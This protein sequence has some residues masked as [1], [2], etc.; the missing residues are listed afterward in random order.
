MV[1]V[2]VNLLALGWEQILTLVTCSEPLWNCLWFYFLESELGFSF[3]LSHMLTQASL[4]YRLVENRDRNKQYKYKRISDYHIFTCV[5]V[6]ARNPFIIWIV[7]MSD[8]Y[9]THLMALCN[10][11]SV[12]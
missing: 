10:H 12:C 11:C 7:E 9:L 1:S 8:K 4:F 3:A 6:T 5:H 2:N